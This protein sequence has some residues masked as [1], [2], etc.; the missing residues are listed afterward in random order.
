MSKINKQI[1]LIA[2]LLLSFCFSY[3]QHDAKPQNVI[4]II[5]DDIGYGD[6]SCYGA[7]AVRTTHIDQVAKRGLVFT[8][9]HT[10]AS[11]CTP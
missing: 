11:T 6:L 10:T 7:E 1:L 5:A 3:S 4:L 2:A 8:D 9:A